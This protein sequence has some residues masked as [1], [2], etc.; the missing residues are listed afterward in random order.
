MIS[1]N[2]WKEY[3]CAARLEQELVRTRWTLFTAL[4]SVSFVVAGLTLNQLSALGPWLG[5]GGLSF[6]WLIF[7][8]AFYHYWWFHVKA[9]DLRTRLCEL[10]E[11]LGIQV[12][13]IRTRRPTLGGVKLY[14]HWAFDLV[15][16]AYTALLGLVLTH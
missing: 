6:A 16:I 12:Y 11:V 3:D 10:E 9:H 2:T 14:Y 4:L 5:K 13:R 7:M 15:A 8:A 1:E